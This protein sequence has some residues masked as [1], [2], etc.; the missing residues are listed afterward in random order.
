MT[1]RASKMFGMELTATEVWKKLRL[2][3]GGGETDGGRVPAWSWVGEDF[4][5]LSSSLVTKQ[6]CYN[7]KWRTGNVDGKSEK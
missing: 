6:H 7:A 1:L 3:G 2:V 5:P 4:F